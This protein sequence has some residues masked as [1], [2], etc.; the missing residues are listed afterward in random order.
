MP[1]F[2][3]SRRDIDDLAPYIRSLDVGGRG[4]AVPHN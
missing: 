1:N 2:N 4:R 3:L